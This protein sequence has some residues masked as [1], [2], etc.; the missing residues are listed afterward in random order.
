[1]DLG[2]IDQKTVHQRILLSMISSIEMPEF[3][4]QRLQIMHRPVC[5]IKDKRRA[6]FRQIRGK[7]N[8]KHL[9]SIVNTIQTMFTHIFKGFCQFRLH[10]SDV[11]PDRFH[12]L[13]AGERLFQFR[14][15]ITHILHHSQFFI[16]GLYLPDH[17][18]TECSDILTGK[19]SA[20][21][22]VVTV[23]CIGII[24]FQFCKFLPRL[25]HFLIHRY[26][27]IISSL[28]DA[29]IN[30]HEIVI[31]LRLIC[32]QI[33]QSPCFSFIFKGVL[34]FRKM[35]I[36]LLEFCI[37]VDQ[38]TFSVCQ[39]FIFFQ[40]ISLFIRKLFAQ[41]T[42][43]RARQGFLQADE[44]CV[45][46]IL[47]VQCVLPVFFVHVFIMNIH[48]VFDIAKHIMCVF[49][50]HDLQDLMIEFDRL[51]FRILLR[52]RPVSDGIQL[53]QHLVHG[54]RINTDILH[55]CVVHVSMFFFGIVR[56]SIRC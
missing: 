4:D 23:V 2:H 43:I 11:F 10:I 53:G 16:Q 37:L 24:S 1:M 29:K 39:R 38:F 8:I 48:I 13:S 54:M 25:Y 18:L 33:V 22:H 51:L 15:E 31:I 44:H 52:T 32:I 55:V 27:S 46:H 42:A 47:D 9:V 21:I 7:T 14:I 34:F 41:F 56:R 6:I 40:L 36:L 26:Q 20:V 45:R 50:I 49:R 5:F 19:I 12:D 17:R 35:I 3:M 28:R 30:S